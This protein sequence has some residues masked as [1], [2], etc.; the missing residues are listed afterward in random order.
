MMGCAA[1]HRLTWWVVGVVLALGAVFA[2]ARA[3]PAEGPGA[4]IKVMASAGAMKFDRAVL[5]HAWGVIRE[6]SQGDVFLVHIPPREAPGADGKLHGVPS[7]TLRVATRLGSE[8]V[9]MAAVDSGVYLVFA[10]DIAGVGMQVLSLDAVASGVGDLWR[11]VPEGRLRTRPALPGNIRLLAFAGSPG[12][13]V[14]IAT[15][16]PEPQ[17][18]KLLELRGESW[19]QTVLPTELVEMIERGGVVTTATIREGLRV[20][21]TWDLVERWWTIRY[22]KPSGPAIIETWQPVEAGPRG[23]DSSEAGDT[24]GWVQSGGELL[25]WSIERDELLLRPGLGGDGAALARIELSPMTQSVA[26][27]P[28]DAT[29]DVLVARTLAPPP[30]SSAGPT[31]RSAT[32]TLQITELSAATGRILY[33]GPPRSAN[34]IAAED[35]RAVALILFTCMALT[36]GLVLATSAGGDTVVLGEGMALAS[37]MLRALAGLIDV[38][39]AAVIAAR[40][41][42]VPLGDLLTPGGVLFGG[43]RLTLATVGVGLALGVFAEAFLGRS[44]GKILTGSEVVGWR[45][46]DTASGH[47]RLRQVVV[48]NLVKW[49]LP[50]VAILA[51]IDPS[52]RHRGEVLSRTAVVVRFDRED[53]QPE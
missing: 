36:I 17:S 10:P 34:P 49:L 26:V 45:R 23:T 6:S 50:P 48:R 31:G 28:L 16:L 2:A 5:P 30:A 22:E 3:Q 52:G 24:E 8:P 20:R 35:F 53:E 11:F 19:R 25:R 41:L 4:H 15:G 40:L 32:A 39:A 18:T 9:A 27:V 46:G 14:A 37:P 44:L 33:D 51:L 12:G 1:Q 29:G 13:P 7:G 43:G 47:P 42:G 38:V 21:V